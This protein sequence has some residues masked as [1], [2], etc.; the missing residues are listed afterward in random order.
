LAGTLSAAPAVSPQGNIEWWTA[1]APLTAPPDTPPG[2]Y[3]TLLTVPDDKE[4]RDPVSAFDSRGRLHVAWKDNRRL[5][6]SDE[7]HYLMK[8]STG[9]RDFQCVSNLDTSHNSP[10]LVVDAE[11]NVHVFFLRWSGQ[12]YGYDLGYRRRDG[13]TGTWWPEERL[14]DHDSLSTASRPHAVVVADTVFVFWR[15]TNV[16]PQLFGYAYNNGGGWS[17]YKVLSSGEERYRG[18]IAVRASRD[19]WIHVVWDD[20][21][22][23]T[24]QLWHRY[25]NGDSWSAPYRTT[26]EGHNAV[27]PGLAFDSLGNLHVAFAGGPSPVDRLHYRVW[28]RAT[29][30]WGEPTRWYSWNGSPDPRIGI[31][32]RTGERHLAHVGAEGSLFGLYYRR[33]DPGQNVWT[34]ST[35]LT[36]NAALTGPALP[37]VDAAGRVHL[38]FWCNGY[39]AQEEIVYKTN[40]L[41]AAV[42]EERHTP[43]ASRVTPHATVVRGVLHLPVSSLVIRNSSLLDAAG[44]RVL[45][46]RPGPN[47]VS[48]LRPGVYFVR[49]SLQ[50]V[51]IAK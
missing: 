16:S 6:G 12:P 3:D 32:L 40:H 15:I 2:W 45:D 13:A 20:D 49:P 29:R 7:I 26:F 10:A 28:D 33:F 31:N 44:R 11:G 21:R 14:T 4:S 39:G 43:S 30:A 22:A 37:L 42:A 24:T 38:V 23:D 5:Q 9:W 17:D 41:P 46:L 27:Q 34:D 35:R 48:S 8:D 25:H 19:G 51:V 36:F 1:P 47:D 50:K 18:N